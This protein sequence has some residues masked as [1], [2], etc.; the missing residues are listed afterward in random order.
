MEIQNGRSI[1]MCST[2]ANDS[3]KGRYSRGYSTIQKELN[4]GLEN[5]K[6][7]LKDCKNYPWYTER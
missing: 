1:K 5:M 4:L 3:E 6:N 2:D 7:G